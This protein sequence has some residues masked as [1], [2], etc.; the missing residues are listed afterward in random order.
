MADRETRQTRKQ[1]KAS[2]FDHNGPE[3][4]GNGILEGQATG[5]SQERPN[6]NNGSDNLLLQFF[7]QM[8]EQSR[9]KLVQQA[10][11][12]MLQQQMQQQQ[13]AMM[14]QQHSDQLERLERLRLAEQ[15]KLERHRIEER[16][17]WEKAEQLHKVEQD[18]L[19]KQ[20]VDEQ[21]K[22]EKTRRDEQDRLLQQQRDLAEESKLRER[23][24]RLVEKL[25][26]LSDNDQLDTFFLRFEDQMKEA[27][28][29]EEEWPVHLRTLLTG[30]ALAAYTRDVPDEAKR[31]YRTLKDA[32]LDAVG[33]AL[34]DCINS[35]FVQHKKYSWTWQEASRRVEFQLERIMRGC[36][37]LAEARNQMGIAR[38]MTWC[39]AECA[40]FVKLREP[41]TMTETAKLIGEFEKMNGDSKPRR[42]WSRPVEYRWV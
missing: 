38:L 24:R 22:M 32:L 10:E 40:S 39:S 14:Q 16:D 13:L 29:E 1:V 7:Q 35:F 27:E 19:E 37:T 11:Q 3:T 17:R 23:K 8:Q 26:K 31:A 28:V 36:E 20:R 4:D 30:T 33:L 12:N 9:K 21:E 42:Q 15:D 41:K 6:N 5:S 18:R 2:E 25:P 34:F